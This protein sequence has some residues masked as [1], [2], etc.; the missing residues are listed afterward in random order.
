MHTLCLFIAACWFLAV[1]AGAQVSLLDDGIQ[2]FRE[3]YREW[4]AQ[5]ME[6]ALEPLRQDASELSRY[7]QSVIQF[8]IVLCRK[9]I[10]A[11]GTVQFLEESLDRNP[12][13][14]E[15][16]IMLAVLYGRQIAARPVRG[17]WLGRKVNTLRSRALLA[18]EMNPRVHTLAGVCW[19]SAPAPHGN[20]DLALKHL[21]RAA[22]LYSVEKESV[23]DF[24]VPVW[25]A[26]LCYSR[27]GDLMIE[28]GDISS[29]RRYYDDALQV[30]PLYEPAKKGLLGIEH[31]KKK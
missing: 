26:A 30:N 20:K 9:E 31:E 22:E 29:A 7:W 2:Q 19:M 24:R 13:D 27:I 23:R 21:L 14:A 15:L 18:G 8:H 12:R 28:K 1:T 4:N 16:S 10:D 25:G 17:L 5:K 3:G 6:S 11:S